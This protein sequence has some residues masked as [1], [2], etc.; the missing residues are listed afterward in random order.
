MV[1]AISEGTLYSA[2]PI[3][4]TLAMPHSS[5]DP[6]NVAAAYIQTPSPSGRG[7]LPFRW[8]PLIHPA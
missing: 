4:I 7:S 3:K 8:G 1:S 2:D 5:S 6:L